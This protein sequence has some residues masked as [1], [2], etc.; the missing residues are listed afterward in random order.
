MIEQIH[1]VDLESCLFFIEYF[2]SFRAED[3]YTKLT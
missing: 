1:K 2:T 3:F